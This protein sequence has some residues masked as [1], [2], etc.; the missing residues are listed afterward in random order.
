METKKKD[1]KKPAATGGAKT[2]GAAQKSATGKAVGQKDPKAAKPAVEDKK[3]PAVEEKKPV[4]EEKKVSEKPKVE[5]AQQIKLTQML[6]VIE[7]IK[8]NDGK[9]AV[10]VDP[11]NM[12]N[13]FFKYKSELIDLTEL[14]LKETM[15]RQDRAETVERSR[16]RLHIALKNGAIAVFSM[17]KLPK[18]LGSLYQGVPWWQPEKLLDPVENLKEEFYKTHIIK[19]EEDVDYMGNKGG[20]Y[21]KDDFTVTILISEVE[22]NLDNPE[23][24][25]KGL[26]LPLNMIKFVRIITD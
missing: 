7:S 22:E 24:L 6:Y 25:A 23:E 2:Q 3:K 1:A 18:D 21:A 13:T 4:V 8:K 10:I 20:F 11:G 19:K 26:G 15:G 17:D 12:A 5:Y 16:A 9:V 14:T